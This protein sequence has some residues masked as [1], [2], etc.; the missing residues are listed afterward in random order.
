MWCRR[1]FREG[2]DRTASRDCLGELERADRFESCEDRE[3]REECR[4]DDRIGREGSYAIGLT[5]TG[6]SCFVLRLRVEDVDVD[7]EV[8]LPAGGGALGFQTAEE[9]PA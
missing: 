7:V 5:A 8:E 3:S 2:C 9:T 4:D 6:W 1:D